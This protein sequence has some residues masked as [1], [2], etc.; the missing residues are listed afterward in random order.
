MPL[1]A[2]TTKPRGDA[3][4]KRPP[5]NSTAQTDTQYAYVSLQLQAGT[6]LKT[7][8]EKFRSNGGAE[9]SSGHTL[10]I[11]SLSWPYTSPLY[12]SP[13]ALPHAARVGWLLSLLVFCSTT[14]KDL[15]EGARG[16]TFKGYVLQQ[17]SGDYRVTDYRT[18]NRDILPFWRPACLWFSVW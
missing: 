6:V 17:I 12:P 8:A 18:W 15:Q 4:E 3:S 11:G 5:P 13:P 7:R 2:S 10:R 14:P 9:I 1:H 16:G